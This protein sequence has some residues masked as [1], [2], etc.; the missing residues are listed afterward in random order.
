[1]F[2]ALAAWFVPHGAVV[3]ATDPLGAWNRWGAFRDDGPPRRCW[4]VTRPIATSRG[5][6]ATPAL[7]VARFPPGGG[8]LRVALSRPAAG[9]RV[10]LSIGARHIGLMAEGTA[11]QALHPRA[12]ASIVAAMRGAETLVI[13]GRGRTGRAFRDVYRLAGAA[14]AI[15]AAMLG[16]L[17]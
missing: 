12:D 1:M 5:G 6:S 8:E 9:G 4:A 10:R 16:C 3:A 11:A 7:M 15:D 2:V 14:S 17:P 13:E